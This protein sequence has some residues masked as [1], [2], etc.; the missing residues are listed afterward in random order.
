MNTPLQAGKE[1]N[2]MNKADVFVHDFPGKTI[3][4]VYNSIEDWLPNRLIEFAL[5]SIFS[6]ATGLMQI[7]TCELAITF[8]DSETGLP[9]Y[10]RFPMYP[11]WMLKQKKVPQDLRIS[12]FWVDERIIEKQEISFKS[13]QEGIGEALAANPGDETG[14]VVTWERIISGAANCNS[15]LANKYFEENEIWIEDEANIYK[16]PIEHRGN[17][18]W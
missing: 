17:N 4:L 18:I 10:D 14:N 16:H 15:L 1:L 8:A 6:F 9:M 11:F 12:P 2:N 3:H 5:N 13:M 7:Y